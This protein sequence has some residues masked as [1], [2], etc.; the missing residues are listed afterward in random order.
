MNKNT[1]VDWNNYL[2][3]VCAADLLRNPIVIGGPNTTVEIDE[4]L[5]C[6]CKNHQGRV[7]PQQWVFGG[8]SRE[9][10]ECFMYAVP[11][12]S[13]TTLMPIIQNSILPGTTVMSDL[14]RAYG[15]I[16][17]MG[18]NHF[19]VNHCGTVKLCGSGHQSAHTKCRKLL[20]VSKRKETKDNMGPT[21]KCWILIFVNG[22]GGR[23]TGTTCCLTE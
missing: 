8:I 17:A 2:R 20:E 13:A 23:K 18:F 15:G 21:D 1:V 7:L 14:W 3:E 10:R 6:R 9:M 16:N 19:T 4:I 12:R 11:N 22:C 5:F